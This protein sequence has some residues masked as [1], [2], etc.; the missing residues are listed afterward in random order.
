VFFLPYGHR[1][2]CRFSI[3]QVFCVSQQCYKLDQ[4]TFFSETMRNKRGSSQFYETQSSLRDNA[5]HELCAAVIIEWRNLTCERLVWRGFVMKLCKEMLLEIVAIEFL[6][7]NCRFLWWKS[8]KGCWKFH[9]LSWG[10]S[11]LRVSLFELLCFD[12]YQKTSQTHKTLFILPEDIS[13]NRWSLSTVSDNRFLSH[14]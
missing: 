10:I 2:C 9:K 14:Q 3:A 7:E 1:F 8:W 12:F 6:M 11:E 4:V 13:L 5:S